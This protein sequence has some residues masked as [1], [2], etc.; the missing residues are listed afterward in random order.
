MDIKRLTDN[1]A[2]SPQ[3]EPGDIAEIV[4]EGFQSVIC[5]RPDAEV[6]TDLSAAT[7]RSAVESAG[8]QWRENVIIGGAMTLENIDLQG[9]LENELPGPVL[10]YCRSGTRSATAWSLSRAG[11]EET[12]DII[13]TAAKGGYDLSPLRGQIEAMATRTD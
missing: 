8:L 12:D 11:S 6:G 9:Q 3:I 13:A 5:N 7:I 4:A 2:V 1:F 10:A